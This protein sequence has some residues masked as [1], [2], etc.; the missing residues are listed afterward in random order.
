MK[1]DRQELWEIQN[2]RCCWCG[3]PMA[4]DAATI[5]HIIPVSLGGRNKW[6]NKAV[7]HKQCN[8]DRGSNLLQE[9]H[10][11]FLFDH[12]RRR[13]KAYHEGIARQDL[14]K[15]DLPIPAVRWS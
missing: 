10:P 6:D 5:E 2:G 7:S 1:S 3:Q 15:L 14:A 9:P 8:R 12:V 13:L 11:S 4:A